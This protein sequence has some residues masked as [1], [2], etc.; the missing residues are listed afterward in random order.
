MS[1]AIIGAT[2]RLGGHAVNALLARGTSARD[3]L[4]LGRN[5]ERLA[6]L[7]DL[8]LRTA[9]VDLDDVEAT[10][11]VLAGVERLVLISI[12]GMTGGVTP[13]TNAVA[14]AEAAGVRHLVYTSV[15]QA[16][17]T[18]LGI[19]AD[20][21]ATEK[22][23]TGS[24]IPA[25]FLRNGWYTENLRPDFDSARKRGV[26][27]NSIGDGRIASAP[28]RDYGEAIAAVLTTPGHEGRAYEL[29]GDTAWSFPEFAE[30]A[31]DVLGS[32]VRYDVLTREQELEHLI[33]SGLDEPTA[34]LFNSSYADI[35]NGAMSLTNGD[36]ATLIGHTT[37]PLADTMRTWH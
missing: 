22:V 35:R 10:T 21:R 18:R 30:A 32:P 36:L 14:A 25:T 31:S 15:L 6:E 13:R 26:I 33:A 2:G 28:C 23:I 37:Q 16:P 9:T 1:I 12:G 19:A 29:S 3:I 34:D 8:G 24:G 4:A 7:G 17:T 20:H 27:A 5:E 11:A